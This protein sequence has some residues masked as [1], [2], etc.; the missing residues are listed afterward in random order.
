VTPL[1]AKTGMWKHPVQIG[2]GQALAIAR[3]HDPASPFG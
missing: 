3:D 2:A 1:K